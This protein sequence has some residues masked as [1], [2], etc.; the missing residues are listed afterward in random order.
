M[1]FNQYL[2]ESTTDSLTGLNNVRKFDTEFNR[3]INE[4]KTKDQKLS[5]LYIDIDFFKKVNDTYGH[6]EGDVVLKEMG[7]RILNNTRSFDLV[8]RN[9]GEEFTAVLL[10]CSLYRAVEIAETLRRNV[11][12]YPFILNSGQHL[13][14]TV[15]IGVATYQETTINPENLIDEA[16]KAL[17]RAKHFGRNKVCVASLL[18]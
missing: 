13:N 7:E 2:K 10:D 17:Y 4:L 5:L 11:E 8:S 14:L 12:N 1:L 9:G 15:S 16:D 3:F 18:K 6:V